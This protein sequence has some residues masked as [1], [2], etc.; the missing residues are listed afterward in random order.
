MSNSDL[1][2][3]TITL[4]IFN[5]TLL[6]SDSDSDSDKEAPIEQDLTVAGK[7]IIKHNSKLIYMLNL[8]S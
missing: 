2:A 1:K 6:C 5:D 8:E 7:E 4:Y 3:S